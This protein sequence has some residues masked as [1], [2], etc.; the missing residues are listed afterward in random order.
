MP[1]THTFNP[2]VSPWQ[3]SWRARKER[4]E[5]HWRFDELKN[6]WEHTIGQNIWP[7]SF[8][9]KLRKIFKKTFKIFEET[10]ALSPRLLEIFLKIHWKFL[11]LCWKIFWPNLFHPMLR[12]I[13][14]PMNFLSYQIFNVYESLFRA[15]ESR[16]PFHHATTY[17]RRSMMIVWLLLL[18]F[19][20]ILYVGFTLSPAKIIDHERV[21]PS[22][23][24][25][26]NVI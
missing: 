15:R 17:L 3:K 8:S 25:S 12:S 19:W 20:I 10:R 18:Y 1:H 22:W 21:I 2:L 4:V 11:E 24:W 23:G 26:F 7:K 13:I 5:K 14:F 6:S 16:G 9:K